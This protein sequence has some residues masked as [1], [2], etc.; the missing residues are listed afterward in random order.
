[1]LAFL[2]FVIAVVV[3]VGNY[4]VISKVDVHQ[5]ACVHQADG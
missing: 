1:M 4:Y 3:T 5:L 2:V